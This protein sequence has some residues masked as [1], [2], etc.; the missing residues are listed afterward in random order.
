MALPVPFGLKLWVYKEL[1]AIREQMW[2]LETRLAHLDK[3]RDAE[4]YLETSLF[5]TLLEVSHSHA[6]VL[7]CFLEKKVFW[8]EGHPPEEEGNQFF[9]VA[10]SLCDKLTSSCTN[11]VPP[12]EGGS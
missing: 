12:W 4:T 3:L 5:R 10:S 1:L 9:E 8:L 2:S 7:L 6:N 11:D